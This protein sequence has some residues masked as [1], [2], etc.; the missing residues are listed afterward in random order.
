MVDY[1]MF[2]P[3]LARR[4]AYSMSLYNRR[5]IQETQLTYENLVNLQDV[6]VSVCQDDLIL[7]TCV[8]SN[9]NKENFCCICQDDIYIG[10]FVLVFKCDHN[11]HI[12]CATKHSKTS[13]KCPICR[14]YIV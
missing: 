12:E 5:M 13:N 14:S 4:M 10:T 1:R 11:F 7:N 6:V 2:P 9:I 8:K 3:G